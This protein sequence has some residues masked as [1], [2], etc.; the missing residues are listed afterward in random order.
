MKNSA[1][2]SR[3]DTLRR[4]LPE[5]YQKQAAEFSRLAQAQAS[6]TPEELAL[7]AQKAFDPS[8][9]KH[10]LGRQKHPNDHAGADA[11]FNEAFCAPACALALSRPGQALDLIEAFCLA[12]PDM[13]PR[14]HWIWLIEMALALPKRHLA[15]LARIAKPLLSYDETD[16]RRFG[17]AAAYACA[18]AI[19]R[20]P[21]EQAC[22]AMDLPWLEKLA[23]G[24][25]ERSQ[26][27]HSGERLASFAND[28]I[29]FCAPAQAVRECRNQ[30]LRLLRSFASS[31]NYLPVYFS[32]APDMDSGLARAARDRILGKLPFDDNFCECCRDFLLSALQTDLDA[33][34]RFPGKKR[35]PGLAGIAAAARG[36]ETLAQALFE[37]YLPG[38]RIDVRDLDFSFNS[39][40]LFGQKLGYGAF[41]A[42][43]AALPE[44]ASLGLPDICALRGDFR[45]AAAFAAAGFPP[46]YENLAL[47]AR[48]LDGALRQWP[49]ETWLENPSLD[50]GERLGALLSFC[51]AGLLSR[52]TAKP[53]PAPAPKPSL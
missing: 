27:R 51:E 28:L 18:I 43:L 39:S 14:R 12:W 35:L 37:R 13:A 36:S 42:L 31:E 44:P 25:D 48:A 2:A 26:G 21:P 10:L 50:P 29:R 38:G 5:G 11:A 40:E 9:E 52:S 30:S 1:Q 34:P 3:R 53:A 45:G 47:L 33:D 20:M 19:S 15:R 49:A 17:H 24:P 32:R 6:K 7:S 16:G 8:F 22:A 23:A 46:L 4:L 41:E